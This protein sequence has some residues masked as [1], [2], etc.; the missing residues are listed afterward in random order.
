MLDVMTYKHI[1]QIREIIHGLGIIDDVIVT[2][3]RNYTSKKIDFSINNYYRLNKIYDGD[4]RIIDLTLKRKPFHNIKTNGIYSKT[5]NHQLEMIKNITFNHEAAYKHILFLHEIKSIDDKRFVRAIED[6]ERFKIGSYFFSVSEKTNRI[7]TSVNTCCKE[8]RQFLFISSAELDITS[9]NCIALIKMLQDANLALSNEYINI[10]REGRI[11]EHIMNIFKLHNINYSRED[12]KDIV[13]KK[14]LNAYN[15]NKH[16]EYEI[17]KSIFPIETESMEE[18]KSKNYSK[19][20]HRFMQIE[21]ELINNRIYT[22][23]ITTYPNIKLYT[24]FDGIITDS[25]Y[26]NEL[27]EIMNKHIVEF[28][29]YPYIIKIKK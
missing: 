9:F 7:T 12:V 5:I 1:Q 3:N 27:F 13:L 29:N 19:Y 21:S 16:I 26:T 24:I 18:L 14:W 23:F 20:F 10:V 8:L 6:I 11:Y 4:T 25:K 2:T 28:L 15:N 17:M 22:E